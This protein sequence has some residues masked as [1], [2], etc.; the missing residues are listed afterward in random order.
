MNQ[1]SFAVLTVGALAGALAPPAMAQRADFRELRLS[2]EA[3]SP[4]ILVGE[5]LV[6]KVS[7]ANPT[8]LPIAAHHVLD[9]QYERLQVEIQAAGA[10]TFRRYLGPRWGVAEQRPKR[11][12][13][14][15]RE[16]V[17]GV[18]TILLHH[19]LPDETFIASDFPLLPGRHQIRVK[20]YDVDFTEHVT[21]NPIEIEVVA[22][23]EN[24]VALSALIT[25]DPDVAYFVQTEGDRRSGDAVVERVRK[26]LEQNSESKLAG[27]LAL[28]LGGYHRRRNEP[29][30]AIQYLEK[31]SGGAPRSYL[32]ARSLAEL[33]TIH[34]QRRD[35]ETSRRI[36]TEAAR[37]FDRTAFQPVF[38]SLVRRMP[39]PKK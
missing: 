13:I 14:N 27:H 29:D 25:S 36:A 26:A 11:L 10:G 1:V 16:T 21:S 2:V 32:R 24:E 31:T 34:A 18:G 39:P 28:A 6:L 37:E 9:P 30:A 38:A 17:F 15:P 20:L 4:R 12:D 8:G 33:A 19:N 5:P 35:Y 3:E 23:P 22:A 7:A